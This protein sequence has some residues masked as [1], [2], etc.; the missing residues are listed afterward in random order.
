MVPLP[1]LGEFIAHKQQFFPREGE[2]PAVVGAQVGELLPGIAGHA[3]KK[4][5]F[6]VDH[7]IMRQ[8]QDEVFG[9]VVEYPEG[10]LVVMMP[11]MDR[12]ELHI[13]EGVVHPAEV[14][15]EPEAE[16]ARRRRARDTGKIGGLLRHR[17]CPRRLLAQHPVGIAQEL[18]R[19]EIF[20]AA[21][22]VGHPLTLLAAVVAVDHRRH[23]IH[24]QRIDAEALDPVQRVTHQE[25]TDF[26]AAVVI[27]QRVPVL[28]IAFARVAVFIQRG[29]VKQRQGEV[30]GRE[31][32][33]HPVEDHVQARGVRGVEE[34][35]EIFPGTKATGRRV[36]PG[37]LIAPAAVERMFVNRQQLEMGEAHP[38]H[39]GHQPIGQFAVAQPEMV[40]GMTTPGAEVD[41][42]NR[43]RCIKLVG[44]LTGRR[45][46]NFLRQAADQRGGFRAHLRFK[47]IRVGFHPQVPVGVN[48]LELIQ[49]AVVRAGNKQLPD[50]RLFA[51]AHRVATAI[52]VVELT[53][54]RHPTG[55]RRPDGKA[56]PGHPVHDVG[57]GAQGFVGP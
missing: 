50:A 14:P 3:V 35:A 34:V 39:V 40:I 6:T 48:Q 25:V 57:M 52:P 1:S 8:R 53:D 21:V 32:A 55:V 23:R 33:R 5:F 18:D 36:Q 4:R 56:R 30:I 38:L 45:L 46:L 16:A 10:H 20:P 7:F 11:T 17:H 47:S 24:P 41:F 49:L 42:I 44:L 15:F 19:F 54:H 9:V 22:L 27:D 12:V 26:T 51:Q 13:V 37:G 29:A 31:V 2:H 43:N 28:V